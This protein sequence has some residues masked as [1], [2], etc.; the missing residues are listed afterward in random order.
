MFD[1]RQFGGRE[2]SQP[3]LVARD[4][5]RNLAAAVDLEEGAT[6]ASVRLEPALTLAGLVHD[7]GGKGISNAQASALFFARGMGTT[8]GSPAHANAEGRFEIKGLPPGRNYTVITSAK[9]FG[10]EQRKVPESDMVT[11]RVELEPF[12]LMVAD[13]LIAGVVLDVNDKPVAHAYVNCYGQKQPNFNAQTD[14]KG[15]FTMDKVCAGTIQLSAN[16]QQGG[17]ANVKAEAGDTN[18]V[19]R[20]SSAVV[21]RQIAPPAVRLKGKPLPDLAPLGLTPEQAPAEQ[22]LLAVL[23]DA[24]QR[25][26]RRTLRL[27]GEQAAAMKEKGVAVIVV[28]AGTMT[29]DAF[30]AWKQEAALAF[31]VGCVKG[32]AEKARAAWGASALPWLILTD[33]AHHVT[34]EGFALEE[35]DAKLKSQAK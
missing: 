30:K 5:A 22:P 7:P 31:P 8:L 11:N 15:R 18:V 33:K 35:L 4:L 28:H 3:V 6:N 17:Y 29:E 25:P 27:L 26:S 21:Y 9:G 23:I 19:I 32:D 14:A 13:Q 2:G 34:A 20:M 12:E 16:N 10:Q 1:P 24:E